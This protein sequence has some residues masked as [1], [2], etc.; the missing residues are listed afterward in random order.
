MSGLT[1]VLVWDLS[2]TNIVT[3][4]PFLRSITDPK[5][6]ASSDVRSEI[7]TKLQDPKPFQNWIWSRIFGLVYFLASDFN[8][9][10]NIIPNPFSDIH[11]INQ[12]RIW[13]LS[14]ALVYVLV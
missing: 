11:D 6:D 7:P 4:G 5:L 8:Q 1:T 9:G 14:L 2:Q 10:N 13:G 12:D 3:P